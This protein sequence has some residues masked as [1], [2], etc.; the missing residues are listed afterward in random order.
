M[1][2]R[3]HMPAGLGA[4]LSLLAEHREKALIV[5]GGTIATPRLRA[6]GPSPEHVIDIACIAQLRGIE[7]SG[8]GRLAVGA[9]TTCVELATSPLVVARAPILAQAALSV[10]GPQ[11]R[12]VATLGGNIA[13]RC[14]RA[15]LLPALL[16]LDCAVTLQRA[17]GGSQRVSLSDY[18]AAIPRPDEL[19][20]GIECEA[21]PT[22]AAIVRMAA[23]RSL[24]PA[25]VSVAARLATRSGTWTCVRIAVGGAAPTAIRVDAAERALAS[26]GADF[27][28]GA[29]LA[30]E[31]ACAAADPESD[32][33]ASASY[34]RHIVGVLTQRALVAANAQ[35]AS[36]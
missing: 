8:S 12:N 5:A 17:A 21:A 19:V 14:P 4:A 35:V 9:L 27:A 16:V 36:T 29:R 18:L 20:T 22:G 13:T 15:D 33:M 23:R 30:A 10:G 28:K 11:I 6:P 3:Y 31:A 2:T 32:A 34:R 26:A 7:K 24:S 25:I 1:G